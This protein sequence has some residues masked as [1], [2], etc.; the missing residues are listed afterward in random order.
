MGFEQVFGTPHCTEGNL[1]FEFGVKLA[2]LR[3]V[4]VDALLLICFRVVESYRRSGK[5]LHF[6]REAELAR[7]LA[8]Q[9]PYS[10]LPRFPV[11]NCLP[12]NF[13]DGGQHFWKPSLLGT[14]LVGTALAVGLFPE[15]TLG[16]GIGVRFKF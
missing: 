15:C 8:T 6:C 16:P 14:T 13:F 7:L 5:R 10:R 11:V 1:G 9:N 2:K 3:A 12:K 4:K